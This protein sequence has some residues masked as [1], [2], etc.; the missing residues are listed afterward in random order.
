MADETKPVA[1]A[2]K[3]ATV[4]LNAPEDGGSV[5]VFG[6]EYQVV[7]GVVEVPPDAV[8][9]LKSHGYSVPVPSKKKGG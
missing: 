4:T 7:D 8:A 5:T 1:E 2:P 3:A 6:K 9:L